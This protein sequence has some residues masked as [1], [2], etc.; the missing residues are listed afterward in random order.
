MPRGVAK[1]FKCEILA[2][3]KI[4]AVTFSRTFNRMAFWDRKLDDLIASDGGALA[5][6]ETDSSSITQIR[7]KAKKRGLQLL[8]ARSNGH[9]YVK[10]FMPSEDQR[11]LVLWLREPRTVDDLK[12]RRLELD[13]T[14]ELA[15]MEV[16][17]QAA[18]RNG[19]WQLTKEGEAQLLA[20]AK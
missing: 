9:V 12:A 13:V 4:P 20:E 6:A 10:L 16:A 19:K 8:V 11:R 7:T 1:A 2:P 18:K 3:E 14:S 15:R 17:G 5:L